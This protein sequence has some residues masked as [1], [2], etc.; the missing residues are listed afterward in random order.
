MLFGYIARMA[1][2][3]MIEALDSDYTRTATLKGL[4]WRT[5]IVAP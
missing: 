2:A 5:V 4:P 1:R 3:G